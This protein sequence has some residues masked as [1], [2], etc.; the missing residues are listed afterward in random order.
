MVKK[1]HR[2]IR[3]QSEYLTVKPDGRPFVY[4]DEQIKSMHFNA[5]AIQS[6][7]RKDA[8]FD[9]DLSYTETMMGFL[10]LQ[11]KPKSILIVGLGGGSLSK[12]CYRHLPDCTIT[13]VEID[14]QVISLR[15]EFK[16]PPD[17]MRFRVV[18]ADGA[19]Y[20]EEQKNNADVIIVDGYDARGLSRKLSSQRFYGLCHQVLRDNGL[21]V[22]NLLKSALQ[23][24]IYMGRLRKV[25]DNVLK[26]KAESDDN[27]IGFALKGAR[28]PK[29][30][31]LRDL[32]L[33]LQAR[34]RINFPLIAS[35]MRASLRENAKGG[36]A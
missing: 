4:E 33:D 25:F 26:V 13:T 2:V 17:D 1:P 32:A 16:I 31:E 23:I 5:L 7:M 35:R 34:H 22:V 9:L 29:R 28:M 3:T 30:T 36:K 10:L 12:Y 24:D 15:D 8:P 6:S 14:E 11:T 21:L 19:A 18:H 20:I 27:Y